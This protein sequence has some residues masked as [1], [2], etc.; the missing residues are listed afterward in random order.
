[1]EGLTDEPSDQAG[2]LKAVLEN[3]GRAVPE[4][5]LDL[6]VWIA[7]GTA[8]TVARALALVVPPPPPKRRLKDTAKAVPADVPVTLTPAQQEAFAAIAAAREDG[9]RELL[10]HGVT[11]S[12]KTEVYLRAIP[13]HDSGR[14]VALPKITI[15][16]SR[17]ARLAATRR[18]S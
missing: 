1:M 6:A 9:V 7:E 13:C 2:E 18:A 17:R 10:L 12:G 14:G 4:P 11:G 5:L 8:S 16:P 15:A 3:T